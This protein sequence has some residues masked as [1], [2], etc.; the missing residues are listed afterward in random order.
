MY[1]NIQYKHW[2]FKYYNTKNTFPNLMKNL[3]LIFIMINDYE[4]LKKKEFFE[5]FIKKVV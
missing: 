1:T 2:V 3:S 5:I 4:A